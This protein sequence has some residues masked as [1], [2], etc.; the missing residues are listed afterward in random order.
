M[1]NSVSTHSNC[2]MFRHKF[3]I[4]AMLSMYPTNSLVRLFGHVQ[5]I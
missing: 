1:F 5:L 3:E 4:K 2:P